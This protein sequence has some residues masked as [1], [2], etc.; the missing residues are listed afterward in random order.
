ML[1]EYGKRLIQQGVA[2]HDLTQI[3][4][5]HNQ[6]LSGDDCCHYTRQ[7]DELLAKEI[8]RIVRVALTGDGPSD[9][10]DGPQQGE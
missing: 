6:Q 2:F 7:G 9:T 3:F 5:G 8:G 10:G 1:Q 4:S